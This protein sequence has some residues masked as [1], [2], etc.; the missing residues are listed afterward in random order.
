M[1]NPLSAEA[2]SM[3]DKGTLEDRHKGTEGQRHRAEGFFCFVPLHL[4][5]FAPFF[6]CVYVPLQLCACIVFPRF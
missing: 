6:L 2:D 5:H 3:R 1:S 4:C